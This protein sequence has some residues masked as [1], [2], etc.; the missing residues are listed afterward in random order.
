MIVLAILVLP[1]ASFFNYCWL[2]FISITEN[3]PL[4]QHSLSKQPRKQVEMGT[5]GH[6]RPGP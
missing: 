3:Q 1:K 5:A 4:V 6:S 2:L